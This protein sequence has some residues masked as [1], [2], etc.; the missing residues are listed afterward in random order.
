MVAPLAAADAARELGFPVVLKAVLVEALVDER[1]LVQE[2]RIVQGA[3]LF[4]E[5]ALEAVKQWRYQPL[6]L[7][8]QPAPFVLN[9]VVRFNIRNPS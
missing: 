7:N 9:V 8:G 2:V 1:G 5:P 3:P 4:D 6:L